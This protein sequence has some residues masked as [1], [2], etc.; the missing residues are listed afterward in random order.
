MGKFGTK[1]W[2]IAS[3]LA[4]TVAAPVCAQ[5]ADPNAATTAE[6]AR[7]TAETARLKAEADKITAQA[8]LERIRVSSLNLPSYAGTSKLNTGAGEMEAMLLTA[9]AVRLAGTTIAR[10]VPAG[11]NVLLL[12]RDDAFDFGIV[13]SITAELDGLARQY[14][15]AGITPVAP[16]QGRSPSF[17]P[18][19]VAIISAIAGM[20]RSETEVTAATVPVSDSMLLTAVASQLGGRARLP[21]SAIG[22]VSVANDGANSPLLTRLGNVAKLDLIALAERTALAAS[23]GGKPSDAD[24][25]RIDAIDAVRRRYDSFF[26]RVVTADTQGVVPIARAARLELLMNQVGGVLRVHVEKSGGSLINTKN[27]TT[28][29]GVDPIRVTGG[30]VVSYTL[31]DPADGSVTSAGIIQCRTAIRRLRSIQDGSAFNDPNASGRQLP[32]AACD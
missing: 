10:T 22:M 1:R 18:G 9:P 27:I 13:G 8:D 6:T 30:L 23:N 24:K 20:I 26:T 7:L 12:S 25:A 11:Q 28:F 15:A 3:A 21:A 16:S 5:T 17:I 19:A 4:C 29:F 2:L 14:A 31:T 32:R